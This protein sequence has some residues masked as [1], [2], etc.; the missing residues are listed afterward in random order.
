MHDNQFDL[1]LIE[2]ILSNT[3]YRYPFVMMFSRSFSP[4]K[5]PR[6]PPPP[7]PPPPPLQEKRHKRRQLRH[8]TTNQSNVSLTSTIRNETPL[9]NPLLVLNHETE[10]I[11]IEL[12]AVHIEQQSPYNS[13][14]S[15]NSAWTAHNIK[16]VMQSTTTT[17]AVEEYHLGTVTVKHSSNGCGSS[18]TPVLSSSSMEIEGSGGSS[19]HGDGG[20]GAESSDSSIS[21]S[22]RNRLRLFHLF[23]RKYN[24]QNNNHHNNHMTKSCETSITASRSRSSNDIINNNNNIYL[25]GQLDN[26]GVVRQTMNQKYKNYGRTVPIQKQ[27]HQE[28]FYNNQEYTSS[29]YQKYQQQCNDTTVIVDDPVHDFDESEW[30]PMD[31][32]YGAAIPLA[33]WIPKGIR[34]TIEFTVLLCIALIIVFFIVETSVRSDRNHKSNNNNN[35]DNNGNLYNVLTDYI[36]DDIV[37]NYTSYNNTTSGN[38]DNNTGGN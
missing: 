25:S 37:W 14:K 6:P 1:I 29:Q 15:D 32:S 8:S 21:G 18:I 26:N 2:F 13:N 10:N 28:S 24:Y 3:E 31:S 9:E 38:D 17:D 34:R 19:S 5:L 27:Q 23:Q 30:T 35:N 11:D 12:S 7:P 22:W 4:S 36:N 16:T 20:G 33:G